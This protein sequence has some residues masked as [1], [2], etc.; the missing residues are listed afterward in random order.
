MFWGVVLI[1]GLHHQALASKVVS[2]ALP[3]PLE[4]HL[5]A[6]EVRL[7]LHN[8]NESLQEKIKNSCTSSRGGDGRQDMRHLFIQEAKHHLGQN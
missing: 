2:L 5:E 7:V 1:L 6:L 3:P 4:F 8:F